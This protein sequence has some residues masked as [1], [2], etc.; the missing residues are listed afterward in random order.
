MARVFL[1]AFGSPPSGRVLV[2]DDEPMLTSAVERILLEYDV[3]VET[4]S[5]RARGERFDAILCDV[6]MPELTGIELHDRVRRI[7]PAAARMIFMT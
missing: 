7:S 2:V 3:V 5:P 4:S 6:E 1:S